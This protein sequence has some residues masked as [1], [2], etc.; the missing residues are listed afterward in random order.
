MG[1]ALKTL[2]DQLLKDF[3]KS[4]GWVLLLPFVYVFIQ[5]ANL[6]EKVSAQINKPFATN[7][8][9]PDELIVLVIAAVV[10]AIGDA[11]DSAFFKVKEG[12]SKK[13]SARFP[14]KNTDRARTTARDALGVVEGSYTVSLRLAIAA[15]KERKQRS[16]WLCNEFAKF[17]RSLV[18]PLW[19][20]GI[21]YLCHKHIYRELFALVAGVVL[22]RLYIALKNC[23]MQKVYNLV[24]ILVSLEKP[25]DRIGDPPKRYFETRDLGNIRLFFWDGDF[26]TAGKLAQAGKNP[27]RRFH[28]MRPQIAGWKSHYDRLGWGRLRFL[29]ESMRVVRRTGRVLN[30]A[31]LT[32]SYRSSKGQRRLKLMR[33]NIE[34]EF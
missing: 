34:I 31:D 32:E 7:L 8:K 16:I 6:V 2:T 27:A 20:I 14:N 12:A 29:T 18:V 13:T 30:A 10:Y 26:V 4:P 22:L 9:V 15:E 23:H 25:K 3:D 21:V 11:V 24:P 5:M 33:Q 1:S 28:R 17:L 19:A